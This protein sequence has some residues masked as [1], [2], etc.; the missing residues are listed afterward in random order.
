MAQQLEDVAGSIEY[1]QECNFVDLTYHF[2]CTIEMSKYQTS[3][4]SNNKRK[5][6]IQT[7]CAGRQLN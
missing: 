4:I 6:T 1:K 2:N 3:T 5:V 7:K